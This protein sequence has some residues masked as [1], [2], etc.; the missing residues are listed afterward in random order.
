MVEF[1]DEKDKSYCILNGKKMSD[2]ELVDEMIT[3]ILKARKKKD[4]KK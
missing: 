3:I 4:N 1:V 2:E